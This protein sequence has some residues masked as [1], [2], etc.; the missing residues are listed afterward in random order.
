MA[1]LSEV[2]ISQLLTRIA[3]VGRFVYFE[4]FTVL[5]SPRGLI[6]LP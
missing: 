1:Q 6:D 2:S 3:F 5:V 4:A